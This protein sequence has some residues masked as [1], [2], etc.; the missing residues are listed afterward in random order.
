MRTDEYDSDVQIQEALDLAFEEMFAHESATF[1]EAAKK[2]SGVPYLGSIN[3]YQ[4]NDTV[5]ETKPSRPLELLQ[6]DGRLGS[7]VEINGRP[8]VH[9]GS[10]R[11]LEGESQTDQHTNASDQKLLEEALAG[12]FPNLSSETYKIMAQG[13]S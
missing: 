3:T 12:L 2:G 13:R 1:R 4:R 10:A 5:T 8:V 6:E 11:H 9:V 7:I